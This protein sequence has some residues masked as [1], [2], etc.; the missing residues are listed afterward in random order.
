MTYKTKVLLGLLVL[1][2]IAG[3]VTSAARAASNDSA[4]SVTSE[5]TAFDPF[6][7]RTYAVQGEP[8]RTSQQIS[9]QA[10]SRTPI[11]IPFR[12]VLRSPFRPDWGSQAR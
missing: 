3:V 12:P 7:L 9:I 8:A 1:S 5:M 11:R 2:A 4:V 6:M 10:V